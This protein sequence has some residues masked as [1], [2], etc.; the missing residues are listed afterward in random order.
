MAKML[1]TLFGLLIIQQHVVEAT[2]SMNETCAYYTGYIA[3]PTNCQ[4]WGACENG[5]L[6]ATGLC[7]EGLLYDSKRGICNYASQVQCSTSAADICANSND[8]TLV[9]QPS[10]CTSYC[11]CRNKTIRG[12]T[13]CPNNQLFNPSTGQC[14]NRYVCPTDSICRLIPNNKFAGAET[15]GKYLRCLDGSGTEGSCRTGYFNALTGKC[16]T[17]NPCSTV[18]TNPSS[19]NTIVCSG[20][21]LTSGIQYLSDNSTCYGYYT[22]TSLLG[23]GLWRSCPYTLQFDSTSS[24]CVQANQIKCPFNRCAN[25]NLRF[26]TNA[27]SN[28][29][30]YYYCSGGIQGSTATPCPTNAPYFNEIIQ[31][32]VT[33]APTFPI[34]T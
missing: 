34:C 22:C 16:Q 7:G 19:I 5:V 4:G 8:N 17:N 11:Y 31:A 30:S 20:Y 24:R 6:V 26:V 18:S 12:C 1:L 25:I 33:V 29:T 23:P 28:C 2:Y 9:A 14:V 32:C 15:C 27:S 3:N 21:N 13:T 10:D